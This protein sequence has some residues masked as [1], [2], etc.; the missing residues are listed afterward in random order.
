LE[1]GTQDKCTECRSD[2]RHEYRIQTT[3][4]GPTHCDPYYRT[5]YA[6]HGRDDYIGSG[7]DVRATDEDFMCYP[8][9]GG[10]DNKP[11]WDADQQR[12]ATH[13]YHAC[14]PAR[15]TVTD[16]ATR[17]VVVHLLSYASGDK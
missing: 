10:P 8:P 9:D 17:S 6:K 1:E 15:W 11:A 5:H 7:A 3:R 4:H 12:R 13:I 14:D 2:N 16:Y